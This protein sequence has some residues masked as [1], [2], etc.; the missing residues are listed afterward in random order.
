MFYKL[1]KLVL[2]LKMNR[3]EVMLSIIV[4]MVALVSGFAYGADDFGYREDPVENPHG[5]NKHNRTP[6]YIPGYCGNNEILY[7]GDQLHDWVCDCRPGHVYHPASRG[8]F[9]LYTQAYCASGEYVEIPP[10]AKLP[11]CTK[12]PCKGQEIPFNGSCVV[13]NKNNKGACPTIDRIRYVVAVN[14]TTLQLSCILHGPIDL[15]RV[16]S[17]RGD[18]ENIGDYVPL[19]DGKVLFT[20]AVKCAPGSGAVLNNTCT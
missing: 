1:F 2:V 15:V 13:L 8:C 7:P 19:E 11:R 3:K 4:V 12:N 14:E 5:Q 16:T 10:G 20:A 17:Q 9:P 18:I 6:I